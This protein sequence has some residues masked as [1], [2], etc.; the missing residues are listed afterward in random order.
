MPATSGLPPSLCLLWPLQ[1]ARE[2]EMIDAVLLGTGGML[3][4][5]NRWLSVFSWGQRVSDPLRLWR[6]HADCLASIRVGLPPARNNLHLA[7]PRGPYCRAAGSPARGRE[8]RSNRTRRHIRTRGYGGRRERSSRDCAG[9]AVRDS[10]NRATR[11]TGSLSS[12]VCSAPVNR[13]TT[14]YPCSPTEL[15]SCVAGP[16]CP[17]AH[18]R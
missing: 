3:P 5:P 16:S 9:L 8:C 14:L 2:P 7:H 1:T 17:I 15:T 18:V 13:E 11:R 10:G 6:R 4:L 12:V